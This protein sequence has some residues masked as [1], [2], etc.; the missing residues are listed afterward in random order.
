MMMRQ[1]SEGAAANHGV[2]RMAGSQQSWERQGRGLPLSAQAARTK[3]YQLMAS[4]TGSCYL[5]SGGESLK[6]RC[7]GTM[8]PLKVLR[9]EKGQFLRLSQ[10][11][12]FADTVSYS[13]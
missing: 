1:G 4:V 10:Y 6:S 2:L 3:Y 13:L 11:W 8:V 9:E 7:W 5:N 12:S